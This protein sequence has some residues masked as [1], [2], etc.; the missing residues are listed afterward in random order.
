MMLVDERNYPSTSVAKN[1][2]APY[3]Y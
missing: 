3:F 2:D 1:I